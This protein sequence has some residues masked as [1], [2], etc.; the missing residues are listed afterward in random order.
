MTKKEYI[1]KV[2]EKLKPYW[3]LAWGLKVLI[4]KWNLDNNNINELFEIFKKMIHKT[5]SKIQEEKIKK[6]IESIQKVESQE[7]ENKIDQNLESMLNNI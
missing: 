6:W 2:L 7:M 4:E 5:Y 3:D 1:I